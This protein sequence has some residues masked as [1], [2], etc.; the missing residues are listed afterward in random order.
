M[1]KTAEEIVAGFRRMYA[2]TYVD[3]V[4]RL[5]IPLISEDDTR[6][7][8]TALY[9]LEVEHRDCEFIDDE[10]TCDK[11]ARV[12]RWLYCSQQRGLILMGGLGNGK[13]TMLRIIDRLF[14][15]TSTLGDA[16]EVFDYFKNSRGG[17]RYWDE[18]LLL[19]DDLGVEPERC[20]DYGEVNYPMTRLLLHRYNRQLT[21]IIATNLW[22]EDIQARY[23]DRV[24]DRM[25]ETYSVIS[26]GN[27]SYRK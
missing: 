3:S 23:G 16:Q 17:M 7:R 4:E 2:Q 9:Q 26:Y 5:P 20:L 19:V 14:K 13:S 27:E 1:T 6:Y 22:I 25:N 24:V 11:I 12:A 21:T 8:L 15:H 18:P 10:S